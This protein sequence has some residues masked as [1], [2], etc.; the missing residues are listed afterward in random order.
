MRYFIDFPDDKR[1][2]IE[3]EL[4]VGDIVHH[5]DDG[6][7]DCEAVITYRWVCATEKIFVFNAEYETEK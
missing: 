1:I 5:I 7:N 3:C 6:Y 2:E 4:K